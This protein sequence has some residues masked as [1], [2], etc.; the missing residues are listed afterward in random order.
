MKRF[1]LLVACL[2]CVFTA[3]GFAYVQAPSAAPVS[4]N[5]CDVP[6]LTPATVAQV[7]QVIVKQSGQQLTV[8]R[9]GEP[10][11]AVRPVHAAAPVPLL[12][13]TE[14]SVLKTQARPPAAPPAAMRPV[15][16]QPQYRQAYPT[17]HYQPRYYRP[18]LFRFR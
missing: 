13:K 2:V 11:L 15:P 18:R 16:L 9:P 12:P 17:N 8:E 7:E 4:A 3:A 1:L 10:T 6:E 14:R 5:V